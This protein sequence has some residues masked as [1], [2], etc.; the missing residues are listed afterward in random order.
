MIR[1]RPS[2]PRRGACGTITRRWCGEHCTIAW[3][4]RFLPAW[5]PGLQAVPAL[6]HEAVLQALPALAHFCYTVFSF[7]VDQTQPD[8]VRRWRSPP[9]RR[10][11]SVEATFI[12]YKGNRCRTGSADFSRVS[13]LLKPTSRNRDGV[14]LHQT[15]CVWF[16]AMCF[17]SLVSYHG[18]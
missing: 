18:C 16:T 7:E 14:F 6:A 3:R 4:R 5:K 8:E 12:I 17:A 9:M 2:R 10:P 11:P 15:P 1:Y 13:R